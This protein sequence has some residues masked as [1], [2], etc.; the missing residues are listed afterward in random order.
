MKNDECS[1]LN[2]KLMVL[3]LQQQ[4]QIHSCVGFEVNLRIQVKKND[5]HVCSKQAH[6]IYQK[7]NDDRKYTSME[8]V[9]RVVIKRLN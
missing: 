9:S 6:R 4:Q 2:L 5:I 8:P 1:C 3:P 7:R